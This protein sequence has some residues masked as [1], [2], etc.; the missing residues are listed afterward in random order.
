MILS[1]FS[2]QIHFGDGGTDYVLLT[3]L[4]VPPSGGTEPVTAGVQPFQ[5]GSEISIILNSEDIK[6]NIYGEIT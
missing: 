3:H 4:P 6:F 2:I 5:S 1:L